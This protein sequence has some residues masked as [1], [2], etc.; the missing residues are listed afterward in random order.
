[1][2]NSELW[3]NFEKKFFASEKYGQETPSA[4]DD[5]LI[6]QLYSQ[7]KTQKQYNFEVFSSKSGELSPLEMFRGFAVLCCAVLGALGHL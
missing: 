1:M 3:Q 2:K 4:T 6:R 7:K 5:F